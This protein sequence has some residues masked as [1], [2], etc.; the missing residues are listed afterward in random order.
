M[1]EAILNSEYRNNANRP[2][3]A[4]VTRH[5]SFCT[6]PGHCITRCCDQRL[7][8]FESECNLKKIEFEFHATVTNVVPLVQFGH[9][10]AGFASENTPNINIVKAFAIRKCGS[11]IRSNIHECMENI[12]TYIFRLDDPIT[13][14]R[15]NLNNINNVNN[16]N[17][18]NHLNDVTSIYNLIL[19]LC[20][21]DKVPHRT[22]KFTIDCLLKKTNT[23]T[24]NTTTSNINNNKHIDCS[25]CYED[26][27]ECE[28]VK[29]NC[30]HEFC[31]YCITNTLKTC[32]INNGPS[33]ALC[34]TKITKIFCKDEKIQENLM[35]FIENAV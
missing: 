7:V 11:V 26:K 33:C 14:R 22:R 5:C 28:F 29:L 17:Y 30:N 23:N 6:R 2:I 25:I 3:V 27:Q 12:T 24:S 4:G 21:L 32:C 8:I 19:A 35:E 31:G 18:F 13:D 15:N 1:S 9:W 20:D 16:V 10:L 34:R